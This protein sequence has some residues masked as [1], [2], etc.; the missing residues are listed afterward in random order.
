MSKKKTPEAELRT[1][2]ELLAV[3]MRV[4]LRDG[5]EAASMKAIADEGDCTTGKLYSNYTK[6][7]DFL[8]AFVHKLVT[9]NY[10]ATS[11]ILK[12]G[13]HP[14]MPYLLTAAMALETCQLNENFHELYYVGYSGKD[15]LKMIID[16]HSER[17]FPVLKQCG[18]EK[19]DKEMFTNGLMVAGV[20]RSLVG[21]EYVGAQMTFEEKMKHFIYVSM[22]IFGFEQKEF[23]PL[24]EIISER[25]EAIHEAAYGIIIK[26]LSGKF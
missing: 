23:E 4:F 8:C 11:K 24:L 25:K 14:M 22:G 7:E 18:L 13:D 20:M 26:A 3:A 16:T 9:I 19:S 10:E 17:V 5:Y 21:S 2:Q 1:K 15:A 6:K 12:E